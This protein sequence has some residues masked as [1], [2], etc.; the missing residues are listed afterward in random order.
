MRR[1]LPALALACLAAA[2]AHAAALDAFLHQPNAAISGYNNEQLTG[3]TPEACAAACTSSTRVAWCRSFDYDKT[4]SKCDLSDKSALDVGLKTTYSGNP[5]DHYS[6]KPASD[7]LS[8]FTSTANAAISGFN[9]EA[10]TGVTPKQCAAACTDA[11]RSS[12]CRSFD[13]NKTTSKCDLSDK[14]AVEVGGLKTDYAGN[15]Y[16]HYALVPVGGRTN[17]VPGNKHVLVIGIDG[18]RGDAIQCP[19]CVATPA[20]SALIAGG[21]FHGNVLAG[22]SQATNS[23]PGWATVFTGYWSDQHGVTTNDPLLKLMRP[24]IFDRIKLAFPTAT[25]ALVGDWF[26]ITHNLAPTLADY[27]LANSEK[28]SVEASDMVIG[29]L[30]QANPPTAIFYYLHNV[31]IH[32]ANYDPVSTLYRSKIAAEDAQIQRVLNALTSRPNYVNEEWL[33]VV[34]S[35]HG[36][37]LTGHGGQSAEERRTFM[38]LNNNYL[39]PSKPSYCLGTLTATPLTQADGATPHILDFLR[40]PNPTVGHKHPSCTG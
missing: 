25:I 32:A 30:N 17:P 19:G 3:V 11:T 23:G 13:Y 14:R 21:A 38:I 35:D 27:K 7:A 31:D 9:T 29:W 34:T 22:G 8:K 26:N 20:M 39:N 10:L 28:D 24:H 37:R 1:L 16:D 33:I 12:W 2:Q 40:L 36:G 6:L 5:Y 15:P 18:L 4:A